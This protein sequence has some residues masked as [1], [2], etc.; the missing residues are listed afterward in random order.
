MARVVVE[1]DVAIAM[2]DGVVLRADVYRQDSQHRQPAIL[3]RTPY[4]KTAFVG[5]GPNLGLDVYAA[6]RAGYAVVIEDVRG[7]GSSEGEWERYVHEGD[8]GNDSVEW[9]TAQS[10]SD[11]VVGMAGGSYLGAAQLYA[12]ACRPD[13]LRAIAPM[14]SPAS[15]YDG[16]EY[17]GGAFQLGRALYVTALFGLKSMERKPITSEAD[18]TAHELLKAII[19]DPPAYYDRMPLAELGEIVPEYGDWL[20]HPEPGQFPPS[21]SINSSYSEMNIPALH[22][23][24]WF[25]VHLKGTLE[26]F[27]GLR[28]RAETERAREGQ[29]LIV[30]PWGHSAPNEYLGDLDFGPSASASAFGLTQRQLEF[31][32]EHLSAQKTRSRP[33]VSIFVM[34]R[35]QWREE[36]DWP[37]ARAEASKWFLQAGGGLASV[38]A[39]PAGHDAFVYDPTDPLPTAGGNTLLPRAGF[40]MGPRD[41]QKL[42][43]RADVLVY[44]TDPLTAE[45][46]VTGPL[47]ARLFVAASALDTDFTVT[48]LDIYEDGMTIGLADGIRRLRY[49]NGLSRPLLANA[50]EIYEIEVDLVATSNVFG[51]GHCIGVE[52]SSSNFPRYDRNPNDGGVVSRA[53]RAHMVSSQQLVFAGETHPSHVL[54]PVI[55]SS[56]QNATA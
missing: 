15:H 25:D 3:V 42:Q 30:G 17:E 39:G 16:A 10:W 40:V 50:G 47:K 5:N 21:T 24:G 23:G 34:G 11:G 53:S 36:E 7:T 38:G 28:S 37:L 43:H 41:R 51:V 12:A 27:T 18:R 45:L 33:R 13:G 22:V 2:R 8:D 19:D 6:L 35:N 46:E 52:I 14:W 20:S 49:R 29:Q 26:S 4:D 1:T 31:Y 48:L 55:P 44:R 56:R 9:I 32:D 54:L